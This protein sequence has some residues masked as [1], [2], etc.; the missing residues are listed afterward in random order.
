MRLHLYREQKKIFQQNGLQR[1]AQTFANDFPNRPGYSANTTPGD[2]RELVPGNWVFSHT[3]SSV[4]IAHWARKRYWGEVLLDSVQKGSHWVLWQNQ[5]TFT[6]R[7]ADD[8]ILFNINETHGSHNNMEGL[9]RINETRVLV[10]LR[11]KRKLNQHLLKLPT[12][13][14]QA[15][16]GLTQQPKLREI[17]LRAKLSLLLTLIVCFLLCST[18]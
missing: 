8:R 12:V 18:Y 17:L 3:F 7:D 14:T 2:L 5:L 15:S 13:C 11:C 6:V 4:G 16:F 9:E 1:S 10:S